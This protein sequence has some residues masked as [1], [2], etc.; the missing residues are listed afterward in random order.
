MKRIVIIA[1]MFAMVG[2]AS[3]FARG[4]AQQDAAPTAAEPFVIEVGGST[5]VVP[6]MELLVNSF[7]AENPHI[8]INIHSTGS[9]DGVRNAGSLYQLGMTSRDLTPAELG[10]GLNQQLVAIDG[11]AVVLH[12][13]SPVSNLTIEQIRGIYMGEITNWNQIPGAGKSGPVVVITR[14]EGS[15]TRGAFEEIIGFAG[16]LVAGANESTSTGAIKA[17]IA[18]NPNAIG[19]ISLGSLDNTIKALSVDGVTASSANVV[20]GSYRVA[21]PFIVLTGN[22]AHAETAAFIQWMLSSAGQAIVRSS[23]IPVN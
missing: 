1:M 13:S 7:Q 21:R 12:P 11:I 19:Y 23:W 3:L 2:T 10:L 20:N 14:E 16:K 17:G 8:R 22:N 5:S 15:G 4:G 9:S 18:Q 6:V